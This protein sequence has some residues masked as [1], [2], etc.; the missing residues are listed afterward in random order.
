MI[1]R[2]P[3][4]PSYHGRKGRAGPQ[5]IWVLVPTGFCHSYCGMLGELLDL[6]GLQTEMNP[7]KRDCLR[8]NTSRE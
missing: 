6:S 3:R 5:H 1:F 2:E 8:E 4:C 7:V